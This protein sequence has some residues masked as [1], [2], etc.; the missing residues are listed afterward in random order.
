VILE[1]STKL[2]INTYQEWNQTNQYL[3]KFIKE[4]IGMKYII[5]II[6]KQGNIKVYCKKITFKENYN[7]I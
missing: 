2:L 7:R 6:T 5:F 1:I 3:K 4:I